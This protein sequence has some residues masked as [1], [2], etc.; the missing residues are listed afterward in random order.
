MSCGSCDSERLLSITGKCSD[1]FNAQTKDAEHEGY[2]PTYLGIGGGDY[3]QFTYCLDCGS[4]QGSSFPI[5]PE[6]VEESEDWH[7]H[8]DICCHP[9]MRQPSQVTQ[10][11][12]C[13]ACD[14]E[15]RLSEEDDLWHRI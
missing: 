3:I 5:P 12:Y 14:C 10:N 7:K 9:G 15:V 4:I 11:K 13:S 8:D 6:K 2:V 1:C